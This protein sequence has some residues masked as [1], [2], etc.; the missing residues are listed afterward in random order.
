MDTLDL[1]S[2]YRE[3]EVD[4]FD[5]VSDA[6]TRASVVGNSVR[7]E[8]AE[9]IIVCFNVTV[10]VGVGGMCWVGINK[11]YDETYTSGDGVNSFVKT[12]DDD[13][14]T[15]SPDDSHKEWLIYKAKA[16]FLE[17]CG[18]VPVSTLSAYNGEPSKHY[19]TVGCDSCGCD[20]SGDDINDLYHVSGVLNGDNNNHIHLCG[21]CMEKYDFPLCDVTTEGYERYGDLYHCYSCNRPF[22]G[23]YRDATYYTDVQ[24]GR[25]VV[26]CDSCECYADKHC[27]TAEG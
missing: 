24:T 25:L 12:F 13:F 16:T 18:V 10:L 23:D 14:V 19:D 15:S 11:E 4:L 20:Y 6:L 17:V 7:V 8:V 1:G 2:Y 21:D 27:L 22:C 3:I 9:H 26:V 5:G